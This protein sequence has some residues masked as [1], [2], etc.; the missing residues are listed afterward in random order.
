MGASGVIKKDTKVTTAAAAKI[1]RLRLKLER[2]SVED[3]PHIII[4]ANA[5]AGLMWLKNQNILCAAGKP[6]IKPIVNIA[7]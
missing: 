2:L 5:N 7:W 3:I 4:K 1:G 6:N